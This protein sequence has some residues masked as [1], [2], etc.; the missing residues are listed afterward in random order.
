MHERAFDTRSLSTEQ[1]RCCCR[2]FLRPLLTSIL[3]PSIAYLCQSGI[4]SLEVGKN[5][6]GHSVCL[7]SRDKGH[8]LLHFKCSAEVHYQFHRRKKKF[9]P[10]MQLILF[11]ATPSLSAPVL[12]FERP[13][14]RA[15]RQSCR[16]VL[17]RAPIAIFFRLL[18]A[19]GRC[20]SSNR[21]MDIVSMRIRE[22][23]NEASSHVSELLR[24]AVLVT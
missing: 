4:A 8:T 11:T 22:V 15:T 7:L 9:Q 17:T 16:E 1:N 10:I 13:S 24:V 23:R 3:N 14:C 21:T 20:L 6:I 12:V 2:L 18:S 5:H 19:W